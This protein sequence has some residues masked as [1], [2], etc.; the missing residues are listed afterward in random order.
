VKLGKH[1]KKTKKKDEA[2]FP[3]TQRKPH[4]KNKKG[5]PNPTKEPRKCK[6]KPPWGVSWLKWNV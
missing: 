2:H 3:K 1:A 4:T 6:K 5:A